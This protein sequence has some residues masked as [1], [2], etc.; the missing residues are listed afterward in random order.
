MHDRM[1]SIHGPGSSGPRVSAVNR[2]S[3]QRVKQELTAA[4]DLTMGLLVIT[5]D[6]DLP[7]PVGPL[8]KFATAALLSSP[9]S[10]LPVQGT[11]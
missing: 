6:G 5:T 2:L 3:V 8:N 10:V 1:I 11:R 7:P 9:L 4:S